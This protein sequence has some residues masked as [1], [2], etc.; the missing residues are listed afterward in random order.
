ME[1]YTGKSIAHI[2]SDGRIMCGRRAKWWTGAYLVGS[3]PPSV[4]KQICKHCLIQ[5]MKPG[6]Y[7]KNPYDY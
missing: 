6:S 3:Y 1:K 4:T 2:L 5:W 7:K